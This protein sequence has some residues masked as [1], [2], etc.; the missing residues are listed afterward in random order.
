MQH[1][2]RRNDKHKLNVIIHQQFNLTHLES[3]DCC[4]CLTEARQQVIE[5]VPIQFSCSS[6][7]VRA[8]EN[9][10]LS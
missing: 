2:S 6:S 10:T 5:V 9:E 1:M 4:S 3:I 8:S 7:S